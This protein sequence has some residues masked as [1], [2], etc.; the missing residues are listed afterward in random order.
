VL[1]SREPF[2][3]LVLNELLKDKENLE[4]VRKLLMKLDKE[5]I[6][7][8]FISRLGKEPDET[9]VP[10]SIFSATQL[11]SLELTATFLKEE[12][13]YSNK[14]VAR[15]LRRSPQAIWTSIS[16]AKKKHTKRLQ[17]HYSNNDVPIKAL[18]DTKHSILE[19]YILYLRDHQNLK[20]SQIA[21]LLHRHVATVWATYKRAHEKK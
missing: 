1:N 5:T 15:K 11:G 3:E 9:K 6:V 4:S 10:L 13:N 19:N 17:V 21:K 7:D 14:E 12:R 2:E 18:Q 20:F 16:N 8:H